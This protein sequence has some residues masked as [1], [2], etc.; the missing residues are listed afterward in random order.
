MKGKEQLKFGIHQALFY[1]LKHIQLKQS[2]SNGKLI[3]NFLNTKIK[4][5]K[6]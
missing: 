3:L 4:M 1:K 2:S 6:S 5:Q